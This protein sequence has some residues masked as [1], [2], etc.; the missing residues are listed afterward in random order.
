M[1]ITMYTTNACSSCRMVKQ[2]LASKD[3]K[4]KEI[5]I[6]DHPDKASE[7]FE[8]SGQMSVPITVV[9]QGSLREI[10]VG[11]NISKLASAII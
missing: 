9:K 8:V 11:Y 5:N 2:Y 3:L 1:Q 10:I 6:Q 7:A 4:Y